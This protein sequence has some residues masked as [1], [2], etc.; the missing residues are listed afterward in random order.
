MTS[1]LR[2][3]TCC[4]VYCRSAAPSQPGLRLPQDFVEFRD[5]ERPSA[6]EG[7]DAKPGRLGGGAQGSEQGLHRLVSDINISLCPAYAT[8]R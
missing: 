1:E 2:D 8:I 7:Q 4:R 6:G 5:A 3:V